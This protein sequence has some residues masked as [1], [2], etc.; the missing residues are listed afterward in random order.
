MSVSHLGPVWNRPP[1]PIQIRTGPSQL[2]VI[3]TLPTFTGVIPQGRQDTS[4]EVLSGISDVC[5]RQF[6]HPFEMIL[7]RPPSAT[8]Q[9]LPATP[10]SHALIWGGLRYTVWRPLA[11]A[12]SCHQARR[13]ADRNAYP[14][15]PMQTPQLSG[16]LVIVHADVNATEL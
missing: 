9:W 1:N 14:K 10:W 7:N 11:F 8:L 12:V 6:S 13:L 4:G 2:P 3:G 15:T 5:S 16:A